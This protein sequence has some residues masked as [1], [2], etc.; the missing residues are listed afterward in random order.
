[1]TTTPATT[2][3]LKNSARIALAAKL[4]TDWAKIHITDAKTT[5]QDLMN[6]VGADRV[7]VTDEDGTDLGTITI[8]PG[9]TTAH[10][11]DP[12]AF[13]QWVATRYPERVHQV[14]T[15]EAAWLDRTLH[16]AGKLG[17]PVDT[18]TG[19]V[20]PGVTITTGDPYLTTRA[21]TEAR[22]RMH[23]L[24]DTSGLLA[25]TAQKEN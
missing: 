10:I 21:S 22:E 25:L 17:E 9:R 24:I 13:N 19:E 18:E 8:T 16:A 11:T 15:I 12:D 7:R 1:M 6:Q 5:T 4:I 2:G 14:P 3:D 23:T 20:I